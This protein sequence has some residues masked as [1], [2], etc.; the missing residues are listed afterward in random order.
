MKF[1]T[2]IIAV[3]ISFTVSAQTRRIGHRSHSGSM[4][5]SGNHSDGNYGDPYF[6]PYRIVAHT[7]TIHSEDGTD[8]IIFVVDSLTPIGDTL[9]RLNQLMFPY[10]DPKQ[11]GMICSR[12]ASVK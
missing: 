11:F 4:Y 9:H 10:S 8:S 12:F 1:P 5:T 6:P 3:V 2:I 7:D